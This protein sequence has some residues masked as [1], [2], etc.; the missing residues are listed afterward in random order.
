MGIPDPGIKP[1]SPALQAD[2][3]PAEL[4]MVSLHTINK[5]S[6][7]FRIFL[8]AS[9]LSAQQYEEKRGNIERKREKKKE[10]RDEDKN[11]KR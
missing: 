9:G 1:G 7:A 4:S 5:Y 11:K 10:S 3:L 6:P 2:S 8:T